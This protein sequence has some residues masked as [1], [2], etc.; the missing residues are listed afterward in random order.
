MTSHES[1]ETPGDPRLVPVVKSLF[2]GRIPEETV[3]PFP[4]I[5]P[6]EAETVAAFLD[7]FRAYTR[8]HVIPRA[9]KG[10]ARFRRRSY[11]VSPSSGPSA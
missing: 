10:S 1:G 7:S 3:F 11:G 9:L 4:A 8:D 6:S 5:D 2:A